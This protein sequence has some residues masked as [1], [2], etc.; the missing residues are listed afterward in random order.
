[1]G[2]RR[3]PGSHRRS[4]APRGALL[5]VPLGLIVT[6]TMGDMFAPPQ[7][8]LGPFL[9]TAPAI[10]ASFAG[11]RT[12]ACVGVVAVLAQMA[13][14]VERTSLTD[15]NHTLQISALIVISAFVTFFAHLRERHEKELTQLRSVA[16]AAQ[17]VVLRPLPRRIGPLRVASVY[18][19]AEAE[20]QIGGDLFAAARTAQGTRFIV[21]DVRGKGL[22]AIGDAA[23][24]LGAFRAASHRKSALPPLVAY[25]EGTVYSDPDDPGAA[26]AGPGADSEGFITAAVL[27]VP[28]DLPV[29]HLINC[30]H[31]P[32]LLLRDGRVTPL[33]VPDP[34]PPLGL[35]G[36]D[37]SPFIAETFPFEPGDTL[38]LYTDGVIE[39]RDGSGDFYPLARRMGTAPACEPNGLLRHLRDDLLAHTP[40]GC[41]GDDAAM[42]AIER[43]TRG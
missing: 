28:D 5:A 40:G 38:L 33:E 25:L 29:L 35:T 21:G 1:M 3:V 26:P 31:P 12:T 43:T 41:L 32:P 18:L 7:V 30:G 19:A 9:A 37:T 20:A 16:E 2:P 13:V 15:L 14:A 10:T 6:V 36:F 4:W 8:H 27:D 11:P 17:Q 23:L 34:A 24:L 39:A 42:V 22:E